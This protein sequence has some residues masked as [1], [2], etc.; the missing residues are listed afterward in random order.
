MKNSS[1]SESTSLA[2]VVLLS[3]LQLRFNK[4]YVCYQ[5]VP[6][7]FTQRKHASYVMALAI[8]SDFIVQE[9]HL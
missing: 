6:Y 8:M 7:E 4:K 3:S 9:N 2:A 1:T 5:T